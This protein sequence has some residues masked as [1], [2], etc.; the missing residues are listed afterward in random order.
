MPAQLSSTLRATVAPYAARGIDAIDA[1]AIVRAASAEPDVMAALEAIR[2]EYATAFTH[3]GRLCFEQAASRAVGRCGARADT[4]CL[5]TRALRDDIALWTA[6]LCRE[7]ERKRHA[8]LL[9]A[10]FGFPTVGAAAVALV[11]EDL[12]RLESLSEDADTVEQLALLSLRAEQLVTHAKDHTHR[13]MQLLSAREPEHDAQ[14]FL[15][16][17]CSHGSTPFRHML[18]QS[19]EGLVNDLCHK[20]HPND[21]RAVAQLVE[22]VTERLMPLQQGN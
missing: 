9:S 1:R 5:E 15:T 13:L 14:G 21:V 17:L 20:A 3:S 22:A 18:R 7:H 4:R 19:A 2:V 10:V 16:A 11:V 8:F 6:A 12:V